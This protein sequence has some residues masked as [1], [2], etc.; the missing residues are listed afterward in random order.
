ML[1][2]RIDFVAKHRKRMVADAEKETQRARDRYLNAIAEAE[3]ARDD[4]IG[5]RETT[6]WAALFSSDTLASMAPTHVLVAG[7]RRETERHGF[8]SAQP[9]QPIF[10]LLRSDSDVYLSV[11]TREHAAAMQGTSTAALSDNEAM[12][13]GSPKDVERNRR[14]R[15]RLI[16]A[17]GSPTVDA[18]ALL[19]AQRY[20]LPPLGS[21]WTGTYA[22]TS[23]CTR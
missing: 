16:A 14:E 1:T 2:E 17:G 18:L 9:A 12:W 5:L 3:R 21:D 20:G 10:D 6:I 11:S 22:A 4:L 8:G 19:E 7:R 23:G 13:Q 15:E